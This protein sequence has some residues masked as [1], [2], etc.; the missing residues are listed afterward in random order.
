M[1]NP[2]ARPI[3]RYRRGNHKEKSNGHRGQSDDLQA[4]KQFEVMCARPFATWAPA[5]VK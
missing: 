4:S 3:P 5:K 1:N 2:E